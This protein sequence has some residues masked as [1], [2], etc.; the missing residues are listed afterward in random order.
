MKNK[1]YRDKVKRIL[2]EMF[3][4]LP[5]EECRTCDCLQG[6]ITQLQ[7]DAAEDISDLTAPMK[8]PESRMHA[9]LGCAPC[10][11][12]EAFSDYIR[13]RQKCSSVKAPQTR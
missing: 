6:F 3:A 8:P 10:P 4:R 2:D 13:S 5:R 7:L 9:C 12:A 1:D 11:P